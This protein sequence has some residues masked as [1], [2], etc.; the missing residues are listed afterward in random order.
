MWIVRLPKL[1]AL[2][3]VLFLITIIQGC[4]A[5]TIDELFQQGNTAQG[6]GNYVQ[7]ENI[8]RKVIQL[9]PKDADAY[10]NLGNALSDQGKLDEA[11]AAYRQALQLNPKYAYAYTNLGVALSDQGK[12]EEAIAA[13]R[14]ALSL[15]ENKSGIPASAHTLAHN[16]LGFVLQQQGKLEEAIAEY[17]KAIALDPNYVIAQ[18]NLKEAER[19]L[20]LRLNPPPLVVDDTKWL[21]NDPLV[22]TMRSV[23]KVVAEFPQ[24]KAQGAKY[25]T[26]WVV[27]REGEKAWIVTNRHV[28]IDQD[29]TRQPSQKIEVELYSDPPLG[30]IRVRRTA[31]I[32][33]RT[34][35][36]DTLDLAVLEVTGLP[37]DIQP[38]SMTQ[39]PVWLTTEIRVIGHPSFAEQQDWL[40]TSGEIIRRRN[41]T[42]SIGRATLAAG[43]SGSPL[44]ALNGNQVMGMIYGLYTAQQTEG[45]PATSGVGL[46]YSIE[47]V[48]Q[49][50]VVWKVVTP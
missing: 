17:K 28:V 40:V 23:V 47:I 8:W 6:A 10:T 3:L 22:P 9:N 39:N 20:A 12:L 32:A 26:G 45:A 33:Y 46:A 11:I 21:P 30:Q 1:P 34:E 50:L 29:G 15:P 14:Q 5:P 7:A 24:S 36:N 27:K 41:E 35:A 31:S 42:L 48:K 37:K 49:K 16:N 38:L 43:S 25:G 44:L 19:L 18:N 2:L 4:H 13:Y